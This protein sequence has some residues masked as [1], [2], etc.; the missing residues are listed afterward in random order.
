MAARPT[1]RPAATT[2]AAEVMESM[3]SAIG[4]APEGAE[5]YEV[6]V[7][8][9]C[10]GTPSLRKVGPNVDGRTCAQDFLADEPS[11]RP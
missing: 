10:A 5:S 6:G 4:G 9:P 8:S 2:E 3:L 7:R 1:A 11:K